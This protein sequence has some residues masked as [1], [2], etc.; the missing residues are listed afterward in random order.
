MIKLEKLTPEQEARLPEFRDFGLR[1]GLSTE[2]TDRAA[3][4]AAIREHY[5]ACGLAEP[6]EICWFDSPYASVWDSVRASVWAS[7]WDSV[8]ASV[9]AS[10]RASVRASVWD[11][12]GDSVWDSVWDSVRARVGASVRASVRDSVGDSVRASVRAS[13]RDSVGDSVWDSVWDSVRASVW[14]SVGDS[15][16][17]SVRASVGAHYDAHETA[18]I[19]AWDQYGISLSPAAL[20]MMKVS[21]HVWWW[22]PGREIVFA[23][24]RPTKIAREHDTG[25]LHCENGKAIEFADGTGFSAWRGQTIPDEW[26]TGKPPTAAECLTWRNMDQRAAAC[27]IVGWHNILDQL[28]PR[29]LDADEDRMIGT[30]VE[31]DLPDHGPQRLIDCICGTGRRFALLAPPEAMTALQA[32][33]LINDVPEWAVKSLAVRT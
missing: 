2:R 26:V 19:M 18:W 30:L 20:T 31:I 32:Q 6:R 29:V 8:R 4:D 22:Y 21:E 27:E 13:V 11:S 5:R 24:D 16:W 1:I 25:L 33:A 9:G 17:D 28:Q 12:V 3:A 23:S 15:V 14:D 10:V 7:V